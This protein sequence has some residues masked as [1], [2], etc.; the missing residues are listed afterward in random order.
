MKFITNPAVFVRRKEVS[1]IL[2]H[3]KELET[4]SNKYSQKNIMTKIRAEKRKYMN[5]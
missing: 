4:L 3:F 1:K 5:M 2:C